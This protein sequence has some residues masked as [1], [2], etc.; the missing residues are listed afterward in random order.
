MQHQVTFVSTHAIAWVPT[1]EVKGEQ[2]NA[3]STVSDFLSHSD[4]PETSPLLLCDSAKAVIR[5]QLIA[6]SSA[7]GN[8]DWMQI[9]C[10]PRWVGVN[11]KP[12]PPQKR[13]ASM[14]LSAKT[15]LNQV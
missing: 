9:R 4:L 1:T 5:G 6:I 12:L 3:N 7:K 2:N 13:T 8:R 11:R 14:H 10:A 15:A